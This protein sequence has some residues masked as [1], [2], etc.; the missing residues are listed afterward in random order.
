MNAVTQFIKKIAQRLCGLFL[1]TSLAA[2]FATPVA[3]ADAV[4]VPRA[5]GTQFFDLVARDQA[6]QSN[7]SEGTSIVWEVDGGAYCSHTPPPGIKHGFQ[8]ADVNRWTSSG[9]NPGPL[10]QGDP[11]VLTY[12]FVPDGTQGAGF[13]CGLPGEVAGAPSDLIAFL[14]GSHGVGPGGTDL[15]MRP[16]FP[17]FQSAFDNWGIL[18]GVQYI[19]EPND[20]GAAM[21]GGGAAGVVG[22]RGD[23]RIGGHFV[24]GQNGSNVLACNYFPNNG[25][26]II[27]TGNTNF[28]G[29]NPPENRGFRN[30]LEHEH[31]HGMG[32]SHVCPV[33]QTKLME[34]F[35]S[36]A[37]LGA[38]DDDILA[39][40]RGYGD[41]DEFPAQN[42][43][44]MTATSLGAIASGGSVTRSR[45]SIDNNSDQDF[46]SFVAPAGALA[47]VTVTPI[48][49]TYLDGPQNNNG[50]CSAGANFN[51]LIE[52]NLGFELLGQSGANVLA[53]ADS[54][55]AGGAENIIDMPL[56]EGGGTYFVRVFGAQAKTQMYDV[57]IGLTTDANPMPPQSQ[58]FCTSIKAF[59]D[60]VFIFCL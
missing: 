40:N 48:G 39:A 27:D 44:S 60:R 5:L 53:S 26:M 12:S 4:G 38:Q 19:Y 28:Y 59:N 13:T 11:M 25:D 9:T 37:Y 23:L 17:I 55:P 56:N 21:G 34:P 3:A 30:V 50:S 36:T 52:S 33:N 15:T 14:D 2:G 42:D 35:I 43:T 46:Y 6:I 49:S 57:T 51:A 16:W 58:D 10:A 32:I 24:D 45:V 8:F 1:I 18:N 22:T 47:S 29:P 20:D 54:V 31:G 41:R 7:N